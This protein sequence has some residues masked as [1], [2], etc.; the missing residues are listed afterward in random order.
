MHAEAAVS[1][2][3]FAMLGGAQIACSHVAPRQPLQLCTFSWTLA[4]A[5]NALSTVTGSFVVPPG[6]SNITVYQ[7]AGFTTAL[8]NPIVLCQGRKSR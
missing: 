3:G 1:C 6:A 5:E 4:T 2:G 8:S 7:G